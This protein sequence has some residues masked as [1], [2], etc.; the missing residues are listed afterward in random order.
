MKN[1]DKL[2]DEIEQED[3]QNNKDTSYKSSNDVEQTNCE[4][5]EYKDPITKD[6]I[7]EFNNKLGR[8]TLKPSLFL[9]KPKFKDIE[10][11]EKKE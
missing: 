9:E 7:C 1:I 8:Q 5:I 10:I 2:T 3:N 4:N 11:I 6:Y